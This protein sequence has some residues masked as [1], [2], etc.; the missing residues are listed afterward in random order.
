MSEKNLLT[1]AVVAAVLIIAAALLYSGLDFSRE[2]FKSGT[3]LLQGLAPEKIGAIEIKQGADTLT[4]KRSG[5]GFV[6]E[7]KG[8]YPADTNKINTLIIDLMDIRLATKVTDSAA[9]HAELGVADSSVDAVILTLKNLEGKQIAGIIKGKSLSV[10]SGSY[11]RRSGENAVF[12]TEAYIT[13]NSKATDYI[14]SDLFKF[15]T[16]NISRVDVT[17]PEGSYTLEKETVEGKEDETKARLL[18]VPRGKTADQSTCDDVFEALQYLSFD[19]VLK[20]GDI[21]P[22]WDATYRCTLDSGLTYIV[23]LAKIGDKNY[24]R[25]SAQPPEVDSVSISQ[26]E[27]DESLKKKEAILLA[28]DTAA[29]FTKKHSGWIYEVSSS[30]T[31]D[32]RRPLNDLFEKEQKKKD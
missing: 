26:N 23:Q 28:G 10:G 31:E 15:D 3:P 2:S 27:A 21:Q 5:E 8:G 4:L 19:D 6:I 9:N 24:I 20:E 1:L 12:S 13:I 14:D 22:Q 17:T 11:I 7:E 16:K 29:A 25:L 32:L 30:D 18:N